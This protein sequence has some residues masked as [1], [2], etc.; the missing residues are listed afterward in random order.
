MKQHKPT[1]VSFSD[2]ATAFLGRS[3]LN[4]FSYPSWD[5]H[6]H[7]S[8]S[9]AKLLPLFFISFCFFVVLGDTVSVLYLQN[10]S[11]SFSDC[12]SC[13]EG[14]LDQGSLLCAGRDPMCPPGLAPQELGINSC[15]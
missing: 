2:K 7:R 6:S 11:S 9:S 13:F 15:P 8:E 4:I 5:K 1:T 14:C 10:S 12:S 3:L